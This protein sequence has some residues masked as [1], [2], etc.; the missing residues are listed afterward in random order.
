[1]ADSEMLMALVAAQMISKEADHKYVQL[2]YC[3]QVHSNVVFVSAAL[4]L[5][6]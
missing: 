5:P 2:L 6:I 4:A 1:M 3:T